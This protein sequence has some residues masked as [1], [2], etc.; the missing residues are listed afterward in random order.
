MSFFVKI[1]LMCVACLAVPA[2]V[3]AGTEQ[4]GRTSFPRIRGEEYFRA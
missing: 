4:S 2:S 3:F 1:V